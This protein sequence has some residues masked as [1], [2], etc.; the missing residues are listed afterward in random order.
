MY[1]AYISGQNVAVVGPIIDVKSANGMTT[2]SAYF[3]FQDGSAMFSDG[4]TIAVVTMGDGPFVDASAVAA[5]AV[6]GPGLIEIG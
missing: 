2:F 5:V 6:Y 4:L 3:P 1:V